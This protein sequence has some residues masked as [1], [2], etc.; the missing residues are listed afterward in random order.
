MRG[1]IWLIAGMMVVL[2]LAGCD[3]EGSTVAN[4]PI[5]PTLEPAQQQI[6]IQTAIQQQFT[7]TADA[8]ALYAPTQTI[9]A[10]VQQTAQV[11]NTET[12]EYHSVI[13][14]DA[15]RA[16]TATMFARTATQDALNADPTNMQLTVD[17]LVSQR[18]TATAR[19]QLQLDINLT[20]AAAVELTATAAAP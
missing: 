10:A 3:D 9:N 1:K 7:L 8:Q 2:S 13:T 6:A 14:E 4:T 16:I 15:Y 17:A 11:K 12:A 5:P 20:V 19:S 18:F